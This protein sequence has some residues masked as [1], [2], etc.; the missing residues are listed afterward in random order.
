MTKRTVSWLAMALIA[1]CGVASTSAQVDCGLWGTNQ[2]FRATSPDDVRECL[3][4]GDSLAVRETGTG[5]TPL[6]NAIVAS[7]HTDVIY[8]L[9]AAGADT[10]ATDSAGYTSLHR[11]ADE[12]KNAEFISYLAAWQAEVNAWKGNK[13]DTCKDRWRERC[14]T[15]PIHLAAKREDGLPFVIAL[16][17]AGADSHMR[18]EGG[19]S[20]LHYASA[21]PG[22]ISV[23][24]TLLLWGVEIDIENIDGVTALQRAVN[25]PRADPDIARALILSGAD[26]LHLDQF[27]NS[28]LI[29]AARNVENPAVLQQLLDASG[30]PCFEDPR[31]RTVLSQWD[32]NEALEKNELY[33]R[34]HEQ[35]P[36]RHQ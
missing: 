6:H 27:D 24:R 28:P 2:F 3:E 18:D 10:S 22:N 20:A 36:R 21:I 23:V 26:V 32:Q 16:L 15:L 8:Q 29:V 14:T 19:N 11:V 34:L 31:E 12:G 4:K 7:S 1:G 25:N 13:A 33:W 30:D 9:L 35:C 17:A 5:A